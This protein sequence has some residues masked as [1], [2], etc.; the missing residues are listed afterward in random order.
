[1]TQP[2]LFDRS[3]FAQQFTR[4]GSSSVPPT[5]E[6][7][8]RERREP[9]H[10]NEYCRVG[11]R[12]GMLVVVDVY[13][14]GQ[15]MADCICD[16]GG[17][18]TARKE[19]LKR[20]ATR[21]CGCLTHR[22]AATANGATDPATGKQTRTYQIWSGMRKRCQNPRDKRYAD[23]GGRWIFVCER[24]A[25]YANFLADMGPAPDR[26]EIDRRDNDGPYSPENCRWATHIEQS[27][28][29]RTSVLTVDVVAD[30]KALLIRGDRPAEV[31]RALNVSP[32]SVSAIKN[33]KQWLDVAPAS[34][35][36]A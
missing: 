2:Y 9:L 30:I 28:N 34:L 7:V 23:Y 15:I 27:R 33:R 10:R 4:C 5:R 6:E 11:D 19:R 1:M 31:A 17:K 12:F 21:S 14:D 22:P 29:K 16:C 24:W 18:K 25:K 35:V 8:A 20:G 36:A 32:A 26:L 3:G 13:S